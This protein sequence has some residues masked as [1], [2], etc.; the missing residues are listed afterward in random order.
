MEQAWR[1][2]ADAA[3]ANPLCIA[4]MPTA[5]ESAPAKL[6]L[7]LHIRGRR[8]DGYHEL[9]TLFAFAE[10]GDTVMV[11]GEGA[12]A[13]TLA[14]DFV[15]DLDPAGDNLCTRAAAA[16][17]AEFGGDPPALRLVKDLPVAAGLGG[18]SADAAAVLRLMARVAG[19][20]E[21][22]RLAGIAERLGADVPA[23]LLSRTCRGTG[24]GDRLA[25]VDG[26]GLTGTPVVLANPGVA[27]STAEVFAGWQSSDGG[28]LTDGDPL[29]T[30][31]AGRNDLALSA[32]ALV[33]SIGELLALLTS[34]AGVTL[35]RMSGSGATCF[36]LCDSPAAATRLAT[37]VAERDR[38]AW[39]RAS[40]LL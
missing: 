30:A 6:N 18:G 1:K 27:L 17:A 29:A 3:D 22:E 8:A 40:V 20:V 31:L 28:P 4:T 10:V 38:A 12:P 15:D 25:V 32:M 7:A 26:T 39:V 23:C 16:F 19:G 11:A 33:P 5:S 9:D 36:A 37:A 14:G 34:A 13:L 21:P 2:Q 24:R 35:A